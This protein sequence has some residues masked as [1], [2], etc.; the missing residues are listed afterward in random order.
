MAMF[1]LASARHEGRRLHD[2]GPRRIR[3]Q[4]AKAD[5]V[6]LD[7]PGLGNRPV[8]FVMLAAPFTMGVS[9]YVFY[10]LQPYLLDLRPTPDAYSIAGPAAAIMAGAQ[11]V[12]GWHRADQVLVGRPQASRHP[13]AHRPARSRCARRRALP[14]DGGRRCAGSRRTAPA[15]SA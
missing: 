3:S 5:P 2:R 10:A 13:S 1:L 9:I 12:G 14:G 7:H 8:R 4:E 11:I 15:C 6:R